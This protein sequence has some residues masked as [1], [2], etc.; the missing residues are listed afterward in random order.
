VA[1]TVTAPDLG[2]DVAGGYGAHHV[3]D[4]TDPRQSSPAAAAWVLASAAALTVPGVTSLT[5]AETCGPRGVDTDATE[6]LP[7]GR[8][9]RWLLDITGWPCATHLDPTTDVAVV[10]AERAGT[11]TVL[12][13]NLSDHP[14]T[15]RLHAVRGAGTRAVDNAE[16][17][18]QDTTHLDADTGAFE[19]AVPPA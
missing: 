16:F 3:V 5:F 14:R 11:T 6:Q 13:A 1:T 4:A 12:T 15:L 8:V 10:V 18:G 9:F 19:L 2:T 17:D 7:A